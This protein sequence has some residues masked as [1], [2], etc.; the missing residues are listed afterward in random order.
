MAETP[1]NRPWLVRMHHRMRTVSFAMVFFATSLHIAGKNYSLVAWLF[2][3]MLLLIYPHFQYWRSLR[4]E[5]STRAEMTNLLVDSVLLGVFIPTVEFADWLSFSVVLGTLSNNAANKGW[6][7]I[8][9]S[10][11]ALL[12]GVL[13]GSAVGGF[14]FSPHTDWPA[15]LFCIAGLGAYL[16]TMSNIGF[17]RNLQLRQTRETLRIREKELMSANETL[18]KSLVEIDELHE[19]LREQANRDPLTGLYNR[20]YLDT[21]LERDLA[22]C[23]REGKPLSLIMIDVDHFKKFNDRYG[24][25]AGDDC[26]KSVARNLQASAKRAS[27]LAARY[28][29]EEFM[30]VLADTDITTARRLA[31]EV[32]QTIESLAMPHKDSRTGKVTISAGVAVMT[33]TSRTESGEL[34]RAADEALYRAKHCGRNQVQV[35]PDR[36]QTTGTGEFPAL[37]PVQLVWHSTYECGH[38]AIDDQHRELFAHGN[39]ILAA[40]VSGKPHA[41]IAGLINTLIHDIDQHFHAEEATIAAAGFPGAGEHAATHRALLD[42]ANRLLNRFHAGDLDVG[43]LFRFLAHD[44]IA[45]HI[46]KADKIL[47]SPL[48]PVNADS[49]MASIDF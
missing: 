43:E 27:D 1:I 47:P 32:R 36:A 35:A 18:L 40:I 41:E 48:S 38:P 42:H 17:S 14:R 37:N 19:R 34:L 2:L 29:G 49:R 23:H 16:L 24:H 20:R 44:L 22:R 8:R 6:R 46:L 12:G 15:T 11:L 33:N 10:M 25:Q 21:T 28:G 13:I 39:N 30:L 4:A 5:N 3:V 45:R 7:G 26:L 9:E 31:E